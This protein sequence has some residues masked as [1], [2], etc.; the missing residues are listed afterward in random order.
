[1]KS[2]DREW[3]TDHAL[4]IPY[5]NRSLSP[6][7]LSLSPCFSL[8]LNS[9]TCTSLFKCVYFFKLVFSK[10]IWLYTYMCVCVCVC[11]C[12][13]ACMHGNSNVLIFPFPASPS[14][15]SLINPMQWYFCSASSIN[16]RLCGLWTSILLIPPCEI[17]NFCLF[18]APGCNKITF[19]S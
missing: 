15:S 18:P 19:P 17:K 13:H 12:V 5:R 2:R 14:S 7:R 6:T 10:D 1:M 9:T 11:V 4:G 16:N 8:C 3:I